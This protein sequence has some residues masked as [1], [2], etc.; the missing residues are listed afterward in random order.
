[1]QRSEWDLNTTVDETDE[2]IAAWPKSP[3]EF[4]DR[5]G[6]RTAVLVLCI[7]CFIA[8]MWLVT[9]PSFEKCSGLENVAERNACFDTL[10]NDSLKPP[11]K[12]A[13]VPKQ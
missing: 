11:A 7:A 13:A 12:G 6:I 1:M 9:T 4:V 10:R 3:E 2:Q 5:F 8:A